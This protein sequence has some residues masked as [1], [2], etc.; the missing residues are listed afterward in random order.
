MSS[1][2][3]SVFNPSK[4]RDLS[5]EETM[6][7]VP[8][9]IMS[10]MFALGFGSYLASGKPFEY[11]EKEKARGV[12]LAEF[13]RRNPMWWRG[14]MRGLGGSLVILGF[15]RGTEGWLWNKGKEYKKLSIEN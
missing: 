8:C 12:S 9:Q 2:I 4:Q 10:S 11:S 14:A 15:I 1:N 6:D 13:E 7:C 5:K 3:L